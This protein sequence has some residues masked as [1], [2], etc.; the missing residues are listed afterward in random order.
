MSGDFLPVQLIYKGKT[1][2]SLPSYKFPSDWHVTFTDNHWSN[3]VTMLEYINKI[4]VPYIEKKRSD[5]KL[6]P[7]QRALVLFDVFK[8]QCTDKVLQLLDQKNLTAVFIPP[9]CT[10]RLQPLDISVNKPAKSFLRAQF[11]EW[12]GEQIYQELRN[13]HSSTKAVDLRLSIVKPLGAKWMVKMYDYFKSKPHIIQNG[14]K[15]IT[16][17]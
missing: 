12:Y 7:D 1:P 4:L 5:L 13:D 17:V 16:L 15:H 10:D 2:R 3:E 14:F 6:K 8:A 9:N 11:Q